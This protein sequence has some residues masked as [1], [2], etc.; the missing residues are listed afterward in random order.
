MAGLLA[1]LFVMSVA[2]KIT[3]GSDSEMAKNFI[4]YGLEGKL[5]LI[6]AGE[7][8]SVILFIT[9]RTSPL[10]VL[11]LS[12][13]MGGAIATHMEHGES[14]VIQ[15]IILILVWVTAAVRNPEMFSRLKGD[16]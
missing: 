15:S 9:P 4:K 12:G 6:A 16:S 11:L 2:G 8:I 7:L 5:F 10:G 13:H 14:Y 3:A 1:A